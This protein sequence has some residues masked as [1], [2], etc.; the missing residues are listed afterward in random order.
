MVLTKLW[1]RREGSSWVADAIMAGLTVAAGGV[2][3]FTSDGESW[4]WRWGKD[5]S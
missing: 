5:G 4:R 3:R 1:L 2:M